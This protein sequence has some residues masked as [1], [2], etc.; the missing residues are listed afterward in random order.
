MLGGIPAGWRDP[1]RPRLGC[2]HIQV[3][4]AVEGPLALGG[5]CVWVAL[6]STGGKEGGSKTRAQLTA[7]VNNETW[8]GVLAIR[9]HMVW[10]DHGEPVC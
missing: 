7:D 10:T 1:S 5:G 9:K 2:F 6:S 8:S 3:W 4:A